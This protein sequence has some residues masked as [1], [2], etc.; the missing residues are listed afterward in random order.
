MVVSMKPI[1]RHLIDKEMEITLQYPHAHGD[2]V[3][4]GN[5]YTKELG[6]IDIT[7]PDY[8]DPVDFEL[9]DIPVFHACGVTPQLVLMNCPE[10]P[11]FIS[12]SPGCMFITDIPADMKG[13]NNTNDQRIT[14][15]LN[16]YI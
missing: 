10:V 14:D 2:P 4:I 6:I 3:Y 16:T 12:H 7:K 9:D 15:Y 8:G 11:Y 13:F 1:P 5:D